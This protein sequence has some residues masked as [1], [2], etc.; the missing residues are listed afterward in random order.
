MSSK[1]LEVGLLEKGQRVIYEGAKAEV[2]LLTPLIDIKTRHRVVCG[3]LQKQLFI[4][5]INIYPKN[6]LGIGYK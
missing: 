6:L 4:P 5:E 1:H 3:T 2:V